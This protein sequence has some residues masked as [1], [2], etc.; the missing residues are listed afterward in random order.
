MTSCDEERPCV[1]EVCSFEA[2]S[3]GVSVEYTDEAVYG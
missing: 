2:V 1:R 3:A